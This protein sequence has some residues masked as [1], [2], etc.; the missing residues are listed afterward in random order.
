MFF[1]GVDAQTSPQVTYATVSCASSPPEVA[2]F[3]V[4]RT[5]PEACSNGASASPP[6]VTT[7]SDG[8][9]ASAAATAG[10]TPEVTVDGGAAAN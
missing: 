7:N 5:S 4:A 9:N 8:V 6:E 1:V 10:E 3:I 2:D